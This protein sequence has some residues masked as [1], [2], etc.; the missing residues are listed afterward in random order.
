[1]ITLG[2]CKTIGNTR[3]TRLKTACLETYLTPRN[4]FSFILLFLYFSEFLSA[5]DL[6]IT[7][8]FIYRLRSLKN[9]NVLYRTFSKGFV[10]KF[11]CGTFFICMGLHSF[12]LTSAFNFLWRQQPKSSFELF[13]LSNDCVPKQADREILL[14]CYV[15]Q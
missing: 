11:K 9:V 12:L 13:R 2:Y 4:Q 7:I 10:I 6:W 14:R 15:L 5:S 1:M 3:E 8:I